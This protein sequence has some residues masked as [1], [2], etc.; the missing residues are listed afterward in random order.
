MK[1]S[2]IDHYT[3][4][5]LTNDSIHAAARA[6][7]LA[8]ALAELARRAEH[9]AA[10]ERRPNLDRLARSCRR[11]SILTNYHA[12]Q[13]AQLLSRLT[14]HAGY[15]EYLH[16]KIETSREAAERAQRS[17]NAANKYAIHLTTHND[18]QTAAT[19]AGWTAQAAR[20]TA[21]TTEAA[22]LIIVAL[23]IE[24]HD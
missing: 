8:L 4:K 14:P 16:T 6:A 5:S 19:L 11:I 1:Q 20:E 9:A 12:A 15:N 23:E 22:A 10:Q 18:R 2:T 13:A 24:L 21:A 17:T 7:A 3:I